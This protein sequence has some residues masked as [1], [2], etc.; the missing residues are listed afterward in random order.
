[1]EEQISSTIAKKKEKKDKIP[2]KKLFLK[3]EE[4]M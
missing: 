3:C 4:L 2:R 1:M